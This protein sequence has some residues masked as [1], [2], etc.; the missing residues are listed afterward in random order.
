M[1]DNGKTV[2]SIE[3]CLARLQAGDK[4]A[5]N[6]LI[7]FTYERLLVHA[8]RAIGRKVSQHKRHQIRRTVV[9]HDV[10]EKR[11]W[12]ALDKEC[13]G[14]NQK[15]PTSASEFFA[16]A[17]KHIDWHLGDLFRKK[18]HDQADTQILG[19][20][21]EDSDPANLA[22]CRE[23]IEFVQRFVEKELDLEEKEVFRS[24]YKMGLSQYETAEQMRKT[25]NQVDTIDRRIQRK[26]GR[27]LKNRDL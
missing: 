6:E 18:Q 12:K 27:A 9:A 23:K 4:G 14:E 8:E 2:S 24:R 11:L 16:L 5:R 21:A 7:A 19:A 15:L 13:L 3:Q 20:L 26:L 10:V 25:R 22:E 17:D 1:A